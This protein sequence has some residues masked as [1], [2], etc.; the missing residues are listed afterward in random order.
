MLLDNGRVLTPSGRQSQLEPLPL[1][2]V[3]APG[4]RDLL[5]SD[6]GRG[7]E[8]LELV[9]TQTLKTVQR[10]RYPAPKGLFVGLAYTGDGKHV[11]ASGGGQ[12]VIHSFRVS[13][14][15]R[16]SSMSEINLSTRGNWN[17]FPMGLALDDHDR[18]LLAAENHNNDVAI[19]RL[20]S[21]RI[22]RLV[23]V[24]TDPYTVVSDR[25]AGRAYVSD[26]ARDV[27]VINVPAAC[28]TSPR[29]PAKVSATIPVGSHPSAM[30]VGG[31]YLYVADSNS[32][33]ITIISTRA[34][35][36]V[37]SVFVGLYPGSSL[38]SS[39]G[40]VAQQRQPLSLCR[41]FRR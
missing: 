33:R 36:V 39:P 9:S 10:I 3:L 28:S 12:H 22:A 37:G 29:C 4:G 16:L 7:A 8:Y 40:S 11:F 38:G 13:S 35:R 30:V 25:S 31:E 17:P 23:P 14:S 27:S 18:L 20:S 41:K 26:G 32:D 19:V 24:G 6:D 5:V 34:N 21:K 1:N 2:A 15:G